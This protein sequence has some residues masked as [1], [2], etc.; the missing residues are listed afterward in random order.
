M[1]VLR[2]PD[3]RTSRLGITLLELV[4]VMLVVAILFGLTLPV[5]SAL[6]GR[7]KVGS[8][9]D[10]FINTYARAR[11]A[12]VQFGREGRL[13]IRADQGLFWVEVDT[14]VPGAVA[15]DTIGHV[16]DVRREY[17]GVTMYSP[18]QRLCFD[19][20]GL[21]YSGGTCEPHNAII[22]FS[23]LDRADTVELSLGG[24]VVRRQ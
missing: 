4:M 20:R 9:R 2:F 19:G 16:V 12:A 13:L 23:R 10:V 17:G 5:L 6:A 24:T 8:A 1:R 7:F 3:R 22:V 21:A 11:V 14:G 15:A 18:R